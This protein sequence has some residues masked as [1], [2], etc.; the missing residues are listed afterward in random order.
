MHA[1]ASPLSM[2]GL[3][4]GQ[5][6]LFNRAYDY[7]VSD[8]PIPTSIYTNLDQPTLQMPF[9][10]SALDAVY[11]ISGMHTLP[12]PAH[13]VPIQIWACAHTLGVSPDIKNITFK[14]I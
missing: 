8:V 7:A 5:K 6:N 11:S 12:I 13:G 4:Q 10:I 3:L 1:P 2:Q 14:F 9:A